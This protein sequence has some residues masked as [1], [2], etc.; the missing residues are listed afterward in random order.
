MYMNKSEL[1]MLMKLMM[2]DPSFLVT[3]TRAIGGKGVTASVVSEK[4]IKQIS[5]NKDCSV[6]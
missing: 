1:L 6:F 2:G 4:S 3:K 5:A